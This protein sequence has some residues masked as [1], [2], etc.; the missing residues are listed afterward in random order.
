MRWRVKAQ[1][2]GRG[3]VVK[4]F[5]WC[6]VNHHVGSSLHCP[7][8]RGGSAASGARATLALC[9][10]QLRWQVD[11]AHKRGCT[12]DLWVGFVACK[13]PDARYKHIPFHGKAEWSSRVAGRIVA[14]AKFQSLLPPAEAKKQFS[15]NRPDTGQPLHVLVARH[16]TVPQDYWRRNQGSNW[17]SRADMRRVVDQR[18]SWHLWSHPAATGSGVWIARTFKPSTAR[19]FCEL[20]LLLAGLCALSAGFANGR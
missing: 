18:P 14:L 9:Q 4:A 11:D 13:L 16:A 3:G 6:K 20:L 17:L 2:R 8:Y 10:K 15:R 12:K 1:R 5:A 19:P 7:A